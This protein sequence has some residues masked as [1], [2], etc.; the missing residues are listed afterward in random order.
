VEGEV[1][2]P[3]RLDGL[4]GSGGMG[5][6]FRAHDTGR[7]RVVA[8]KRLPRQLAVDQEYRA[9]FQRESALVAQLREPHIIPI[10][11]YGEI[12]GQLYIDMR[13]VEGKDLA[14][15]LAAGPLGVSR[16]VDVV[17][18]IAD[19]LDAAHAEG[20]VHRDVKPSN[21]L[22][23]GRPGP[24][25]VTVTDRGVAYLV[26]FGIARAVDGPTLSAAGLAMGSSGYMAPERLTGDDWDLRVD[27]YS[28]ACVLYEC[29]VGSRPFPAKSLPAAINAHLNTPPPRPSQHRPE[30]PVGFDEVV[31]AGMAKDPAQRYSSAG[32][33]AAAARALLTS[34]TGSQPFP[35]RARARPARPGPAR[36]PV[37]ARAR[38]RPRVPRRSPGPPDRPGSAADGPAAAADRPRA[39]PPAAGNRTGRGDQRTAAHPTTPAGRCAPTTPAARSAP[40]DRPPPAASPGVGCSSAG[41][42]PSPSPAARCGAGSS[43]PA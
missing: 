13:L 29:L 11:D 21:I 30:L 7:D 23:V 34:R 32:R 40:P 6:V 17:S 28:L 38:R 8:L 24:D 35:C 22:L 42:S 12:D 1:F 27:V 19:A 36:P 26:D 20:L 25:G 9:R 43:W 15:V 33:L 16:A 37:R 10:H 3:Y 14:K 39:G 2:G 5:E 18:Q 41:P 31:A 4:I